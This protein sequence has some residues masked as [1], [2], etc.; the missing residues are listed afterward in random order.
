[1]CFQKRKG[2]K[3]C[4]CYVLIS[5][6]L[7]TISITNKS[8][9]FCEV[10]SVT[11]SE[12][13]LGKVK[14]LEILCPTDMSEAYLRNYVIL[15]HL[16]SFLRSRARHGGHRVINPE[17]DSPINQFLF[18]W[19]GV[20]SSPSD[21]ETG[22]THPKV[23]QSSEVDQRRTKMR[24]YRREKAKEVISHA[25]AQTKGASDSALKPLVNSRGRRTTL[26]HQ[27]TH[28]RLVH[29][30]P[31]R[32]VLLFGNSRGRGSMSSQLQRQKWRSLRRRVPRTYP[33]RSFD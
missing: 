2:L 13:V 7:F 30:I 26:H 25:H 27:G 8:C 23:S 21:H 6:G 1:M 31:P 32:V 3:L 29:W 16:L 5:P 4:I 12:S 24:F 11:Y 17:R 18:L 10:L 28:T 20:E 9:Y 33:S 19:G 14:A 22:P 15:T